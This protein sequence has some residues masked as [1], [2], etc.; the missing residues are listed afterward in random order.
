VV[1][2]L[3]QLADFVAAIGSAEELGTTVVESGMRSAEGLDMVQAA[4]ILLAG[5]AGSP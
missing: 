1:V 2:E 4:D 5:V 3:R